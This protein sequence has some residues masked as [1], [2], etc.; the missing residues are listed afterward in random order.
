MA[1]HQLWVCDLLERVKLKMHLIPPNTRLYVKRSCTDAEEQHF[2]LACEIDFIVARII[3]INTV[4]NTYHH[5]EYE[6]Q[7]VTT[8]HFCTTN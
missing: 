8:F 2:N 1:E 3:T 7:L 6:E 4:R 5:T